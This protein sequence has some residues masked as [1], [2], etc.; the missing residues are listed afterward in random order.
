MGPRAR[1]LARLVVPSLALVAIVVSIGAAAYADAVEVRVVIPPSQAPGSPSDTVPPAS[2]P[3]APT[4]SPGSPDGAPADQ[5]VSPPTVQAPSETTSTVPDPS[6]PSGVR[7]P[8][9][10]M[11]G[12]GAVRLFAVAV[13][14][15]TAGS[16]LV[17]QG[18]DHP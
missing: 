1:L 2:A 11:T 12:A 13:L 10:A 5:P 6:G 7:P 18:A 14:A 8:V 3:G 15:L 17:T 9:L 16:L 4:T